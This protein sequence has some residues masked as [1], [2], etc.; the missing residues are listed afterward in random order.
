MLVPFSRFNKGLAPDGLTAINDGSNV[1]K[2]N[3]LHRKCSLLTI[4]NL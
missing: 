4:D 2:A 3:Y 1:R